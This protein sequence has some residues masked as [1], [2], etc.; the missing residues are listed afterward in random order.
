MGTNIKVE[1]TTVLIQQNAFLKCHQQQNDG[2]FIWASMWTMSSEFACVRTCR[3]CC[4]LSHIESVNY[5]AIWRHMVPK[6]SGQWS[7][8]A[9]G[10]CI[11]ITNSKKKFVF[12]LRCI[13]KHFLER[14]LHFEKKI[15]W[16]FL[17]L[18]VRLSINLAVGLMIRLGV[19]GR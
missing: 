11:N 4:R 14:K 9:K 12:C 18:W 1:N 3:A 2:H 17:C 10:N 19:N 7:Y 13:Q 8:G 5:G 15:Y 16:S 6:W